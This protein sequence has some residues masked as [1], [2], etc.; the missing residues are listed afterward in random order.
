MSNMTGIIL[1]NEMADFDT[2]ASQPASSVNYIAPGKMPLSA[3][4]PIIVLNEN[5]GDV[6]LVAGSAG[7]RAIITG[8]AWVS[9]SVNDILAM[10]HYFKI[11]MFCKTMIN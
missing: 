11:H 8:N 9:I 2:P 4:S 1:N 3:M 5:T 6:D 10:L 7:S